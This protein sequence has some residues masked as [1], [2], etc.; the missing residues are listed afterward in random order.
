LLQVAALP[1]VMF[2]CY[3]GLIAWFRSRGGYAPQVLVAGAGE[4]ATG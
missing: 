1:L 2:A 4:R 3:L